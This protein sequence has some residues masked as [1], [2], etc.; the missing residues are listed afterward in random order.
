MN[1]DNLNIQE[2]AKSDWMSLV[3]KHKKKKKGLPALSKL[4]TNAGN[5]EHNVTMFNKMTGPVDGPSNNP[6]SGPFGGDVSVS[7]SMGES[8]DLF[9]GLV[10]AT[11]Y[12]MRNDGKVFTC[13][14]YHPYIKPLLS[15][16][17][18]TAIKHL[19]ERHQ[20]KLRWFFN[21]TQDEDTRLNI[22]TLVNSVIEYCDYYNLS[23]EDLSAFKTSLNYSDTGVVTKFDLEVL[24]ELLNQK[25]NQEFC[26]FRTSKQ[27]A[28]AGANKDIYFRISSVNFDWF[29]LIRDFVNKNKNWIKSI[30]IAADAQA[31]KEDKIYNHNGKLIDHM[32]V[33]EFILLEGN[34]IIENFDLQ[35]GVKLKDAY[36]KGNPLYWV[37]SNKSKLEAYIDANFINKQKIFE[38]SDMNNE[39]IELEYDNLKL[40][41]VPVG[42]PYGVFDR[43]Y[44]NYV[45]DDRTTDVTVDWTLSVRKDDIIQ[46]LMLEEDVQN[47]LWREDM[48]NEEY[49]A[50]VVENFDNLL[51]K[52]MS[53]ILEA[54]KEEAIEDAIRNGDF[55]EYY[56]YEPDYDPYDDM[57]ECVD[58]ENGKSHC[59]LD[60]DFDMSLRSIL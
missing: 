26:R 15:E 2:D 39:V 54:F 41:D 20:D 55:D 9:E 57:Y 48:S 18:K 25:T 36:V 10:V 32:L 34:P 45:P 49:E 53:N 24:F 60:D 50:L 46:Q 23:L 44:G 17:N 13:G 42:S 29:P 30:T 4:N 59:R 27:Y 6:I 16:T 43:A 7:S 40:T 31:G 14:E 5:V 51:D 22:I 11:P 35:N 47:E 3:N 8:L 12:M 37:E 33:K 1:K 52:H 56:D 28:G 38:D 21:H 58:A 19:F